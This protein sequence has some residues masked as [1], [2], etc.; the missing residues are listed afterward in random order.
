MK[1]TEEQIHGKK[2]VAPDERG[3]AAAQPDISENALVN[4]SL[5]QMPRIMARGL[6][7]VCLLTVVGAAVYS[8]FGRIDVVVTCRAVAWPEAHKVKVHSDRSGMIDRVYIAEG[9]QV[10]KG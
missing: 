7:Y 6:L 10:E 2:P 1:K 3:E 9:A 8:V 4:E 5:R